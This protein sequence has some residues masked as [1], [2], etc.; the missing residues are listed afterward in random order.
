[1]ESKFAAIEEGCPMATR[2]TDRYRCCTTVD[3][4][5]VDLSLTINGSSPLL[6]ASEGTVEQRI[7]Q[8]SFPRTHPSQEYQSRVVP[9]PVRSP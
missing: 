7:R 3:T 2:L 6:T 5:V 1:M 4:F 8:D 9:Y